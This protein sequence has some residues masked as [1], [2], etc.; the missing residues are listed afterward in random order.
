MNDASFL[1][2][3]AN[4]RPLSP[5][6]GMPLESLPRQADQPAGDGYAPGA[7][8]PA[9]APPGVSPESQPAGLNPGLII[10]ALL[11]HH[12]N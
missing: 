9:P 11:S 7:V 3:G 5:T 12:E 1:P 6:T 2:G 4:W 8:P 10:A